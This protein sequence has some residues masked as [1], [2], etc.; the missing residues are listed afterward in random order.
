MK[1]TGRKLLQSDID[2][3]S[4]HAGFH[5]GKKKLATIADVLSPSV[6]TRTV[7]D[8][9]LPEQVRLI[10]ARLRREKHYV[11]LQVL[12]FEGV[13]DK[14]KAIEEIRSLSQLGL[15][16]LKIEMEYLKIQLERK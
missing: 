7:D 5:T 15:H 11:P 4:V 2:V 6:S 13:V 9:S 14:T 12:G 16:L 3:N 1:R 10:V 8:L